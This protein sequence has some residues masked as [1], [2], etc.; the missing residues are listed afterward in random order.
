MEQP[1]KKL[2]PFRRTIATIYAPSDFPAT[3]G[4]DPATYRY[5]QTIDHKHVTVAQKLAQTTR[6]EAERI[7]EF[8][9][10]LIETT[11]I[12]RSRNV[13]QAAHDAD[14]TLVMLLKVLGR[15]NRNQDDLRVSHLCAHITPMTKPSQQGIDQHESG[16]NPI[17][18]HRFLHSVI[19][20]QHP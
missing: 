2:L 17:G 8:V 13:V 14:R 18:V 11:D 6:N 3:R 9:Q 7:S 15:D 16:Y 1:A 4:A 5:R 12:E 20:F 19:W 10:A